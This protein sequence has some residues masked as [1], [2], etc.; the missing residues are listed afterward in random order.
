MRP[1]FKLCLWL[2][3]FSFFHDPPS[4]T[5]SMIPLLQFHL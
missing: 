5:S 3:F 2:H 4:S 1:L